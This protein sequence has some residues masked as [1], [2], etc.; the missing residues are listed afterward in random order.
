MVSAGGDV[1]LV[2]WRSLHGRKANQTARLARAGPLC[3]LALV[4]LLCLSSTASAYP[5]NAG[6]FADG[7]DRST[8]TF[9]VGTSEI[10][11]PSL[12]LPTNGTVTAGSIVVEGRAGYVNSTTFETTTAD[13][14]SNARADNLS[15][16]SGAV[17]LS[18]ASQVLQFDASNSFGNASL[19]NTAI[20]ASRL[21][22]QSGSNG[23]F[24][25]GNISA[26]TGGWGTLTASGSVPAGASV[27]FSLLYPNGSVAASSVGIGA[28]VALDPI[29]AA[30][31][32]IRGTLSAAPNGS[33]PGLAWVALG[34]QAGDTL[35][36]SGVSRTAT[37]PVW[38]P[39]GSVTTTFSTSSF[40]RYAN[41]PVLANA[42]STWYSGYA[43]YGTVVRMGNEF[44]MYFSGATCRSCQYHIGRAVSTDL[45]TWAVDTNP[46]LNGTAGNWSGPGVGN[47]YVLANPW[48]S[49]YLMY[50]QGQNATTQ[51]V[52]LA[53]SSDG[54]TWTEAIGNPVFR[55][56]SAGAWDDSVVGEVA[57]MDY[58]SSSGQLRMWYAGNRNG[59]E[60]DM[61]MANSTD[62]VTWT[63][64][65]NNPV[66]ARSGT[67]DSSSA[68]AGGMLF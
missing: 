13:F 1:G 2:N 26:P 10:Q 9:D 43:G 48:G 29:S 17:S 55:P 6:G 11:G 32:R 25:T 20:A 24:V 53:T 59:Q 38:L 14:L 68:A 34:Q 23:S 21:S 28:A 4:V 67:C 61:G 16:G 45:V 63:R 40:T 62:G 60:R 37:N 58:N 41:N 50:F 47:A 49:G 18:N 19:N 46:V 3:A 39:D 64:Y 5:L 42:A 56:G 57:G 66:I 27:N 8:L 65:A 36:G 51:G 22:I 33:S 44:W 31:L 35:I 54:L 52:G 30:T 15:I 7:S 12:R